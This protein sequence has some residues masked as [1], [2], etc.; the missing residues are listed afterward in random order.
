MPGDWIFAPGGE[1]DLAN[2]ER[3][4][5]QWYQVI[6]ET[7]PDRV[8]VDLSDVTFLDGAGISVLAGLVRRQYLRRGSVAVLNPSAFALRV[9]GITGLSRV[10]EIL[11]GPP[12]AG[13]A[14][15]P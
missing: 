14:R 9:M 6:A 10:V 15:S 13:P 1:F 11:F 4:R 5:H 8:I 7:E 2:A 3:L 12:E